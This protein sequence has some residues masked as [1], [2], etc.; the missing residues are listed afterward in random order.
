[1]FRFIVV[2]NK[3]KARNNHHKKKTREYK[4]CF[5][6]KKW[7]F[8]T[9]FLQHFFLLLVVMVSVVVVSSSLSVQRESFAILQIHTQ[10]NHDFAVAF[11][12]KIKNYAQPF[13]H[14][15][16]ITN[17]KHSK[18]IQLMYVWSNYI[19]IYI[20]IFIHNLLLQI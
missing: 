18:N 8:K 11:A 15:Y 9:T 3:K 17:T 1:M 14:F 16:S 7:V 4:N 6:H 10:N 2:I 5:T 20:Y 12:Q 13:P 19:Y